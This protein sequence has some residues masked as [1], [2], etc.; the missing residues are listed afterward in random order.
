MSGKFSRGLAVADGSLDMFRATPRLA[1][2]PLC[3]LLLAVVAGIVASQ[4]LRM[5]ARVAPYEYATNDHRV[6]P[7]ER[8]DPSQIFPESS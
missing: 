8:R 3:S 6:G 4:V 1:V 2:L 7:F 5:V